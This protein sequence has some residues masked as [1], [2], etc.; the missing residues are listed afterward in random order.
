[1]MKKY[2]VLLLLVGCGAIAQNVTQTKAE[3]TEILCHQWKIDYATIDGTQ[4][5]M[6]AKIE[7]GFNRN[8]TYDM[9]V[10]GEITNGN[11]RFDEPGHFIEVETKKGKKIHITSLTE[12]ELT[13]VEVRTEYGDGDTPGGSVFH[14][15]RID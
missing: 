4:L 15:V 5:P 10:I 3:V 14:G 7:I 12:K 8:N 1:M 6:Q 2:F 13:F 11:W 9:T